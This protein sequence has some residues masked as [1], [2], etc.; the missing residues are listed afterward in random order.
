MNKAPGRRNMCDQQFWEKH[1]S[2]APTQ[3]PE[4]GGQA[5]AGPGVRTTQTGAREAKELS[6]PIT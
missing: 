1:T 3:R 2:Q 4:A 6:I 5:E